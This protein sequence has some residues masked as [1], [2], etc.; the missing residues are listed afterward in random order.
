MDFFSYYFSR[1][2]HSV[3]KNL[4]KIGYKNMSNLNGILFLGLLVAETV[5]LGD[6]ASKRTLTEI[7]KT[8]NSRPSFSTLKV[9]KPRKKLLDKLVL[10]KVFI[11]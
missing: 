9:D 5:C 10:C 7:I 1:Q 11:D 3:F 4:W 8:P 2:E 6:E